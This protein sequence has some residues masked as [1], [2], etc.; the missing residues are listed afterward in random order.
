MDA[1]AL[2]QTAARQ[3]GLFTRAQARRSGYSTYQ[4][5]RRLATGEWVPVLG[6]VLATAATHVTSRTR[7][8]AASLAVPGAV[9]AGPSAAR[10]YAMPVPD[11]VPCVALARNSHPRHPVGQVLRDPLHPWDVHLLGGIPVTSRPRTVFD[12]VRLL[13]DPAA[14]DLLDRALQ[15]RWITLEDFTSRVR[16]FAGRHGAARMARLAQAAGAGAHSAA[17]R[18]AAHLLQVGRV[19]GWQANAEIHDRRGRLIGIGDIV[20]GRERLIVE[21]DG[22]A[23]H[24]APDRFERDRDR[25]NRL[26]AEGWT[27]LRFTWRDLTRRPAEVVA[28]VRTLRQRL[29]RGQ[30][31]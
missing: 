5:R 16:G 19:T 9:L 31:A 26:V 23:H 11:S 8:L 28:T 29:G 17:E 4:I 14:L 30:G 1:A 2:A 15:Q 13:P 21:V 3:R 12:C 18:L 20:F 25:Q 24:I 22:R 6:P 10:M 7:D 27:V